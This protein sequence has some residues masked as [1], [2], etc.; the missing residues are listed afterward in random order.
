MRLL[1]TLAFV[2]GSVL[3]ATFAAPAFAQF[4]HLQCYPIKDTLPRAKYSADLLPATTPPFAA[5]LGCEIKVPAKLVCLAVEKANV[6]PTPPLPVEGTDA[7]SVFCYALR[8]PKGTTIPKGGRACLW[9]IAAN[10]DPRQFEDPHRFDITRTP[11]DHVAFGPGGPH[12]CLGSNLARLEIRTIFEELL[13]RLPDIEQAG[14]PARLRSNFI[15]GI[16][17]LPVRFSARTG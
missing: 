13:R 11:N 7:R 10:R 12:Y 15:S 5:A 4:D 14:E 2:S 8:C 9:F 17:H 6:A 3:T 16:K 1:Q